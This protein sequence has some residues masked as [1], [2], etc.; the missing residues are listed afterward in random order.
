MNLQGEKIERFGQVWEWREKNLLMTGHW[1]STAGN[2]VFIFPPPDDSAEWWINIMDEDVLN[3]T[4]EDAE[5]RAFCVAECFT[6]QDRR[7]DFIMTRSSATT[8]D[9]PKTESPSQGLYKTGRDEGK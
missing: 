1:K 2:L 5:K 8:E 9:L 4:G 7:G 3:F 6:R